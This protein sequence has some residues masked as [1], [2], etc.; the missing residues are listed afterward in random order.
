MRTVGQETTTVLGCFKYNDIPRNITDVKFS[1]ICFVR[2]FS[3]DPSS[4]Y[5]YHNLIK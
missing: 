3:M 2:H 5:H 1:W 4:K